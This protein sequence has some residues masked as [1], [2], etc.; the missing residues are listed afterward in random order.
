VS[1]CGDKAGTLEEDVFGH[2]EMVDSATLKAWL[3]ERV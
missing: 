2:R 1:W 3:F